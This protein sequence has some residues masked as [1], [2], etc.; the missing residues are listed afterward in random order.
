VRTVEHGELLVVRAAGHWAVVEQEAEARAR[1]PVEV[2]TLHPLALRRQHHVKVPGEDVD[3]QLR[4]QG[5]QAVQEVEEAYLGTGRGV[6][7]AQQGHG[8]VELPA[9]DQNVTARLRGAAVGRAVAVRGIDKN[10]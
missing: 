3:V 8:A 5:A 6:V 10:T 2:D 4:L 1:H 9:G 7:A